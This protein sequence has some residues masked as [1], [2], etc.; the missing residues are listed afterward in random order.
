MRRLNSLGREGLILKELEHLPSDIESLYETILA[1]C[2]KNRNPDERELLKG[3]FAWLAYAKSKLRVGEANILIGLMKTEMS[4]SIEEELDGR[5]SRLLRVSGNDDK[6]VGDDDSSENELDQ[7]IEEDSE[8]A[9]QSASDADNLLGFQ[10]RSLRAYFRRP[11]D[12][13]EGLRSTATQAH[14]TIFSM[15]SAILSK[16]NKGESSAAQSNL[17]DYA[18]KWVFTHLLEIGVDQVNDRQ[19]AV[20]L[21]SL[22]NILSN[23]NDALK[24]IEA[25][26]EGNTTIFE[27][28]TDLEAVLEA[29]T[30]WSK[31]AIRMSSN[32]LSYEAINFYRPL[33]QEPYRVFIPIARAHI[34][35]WFAARWQ[36]DSYAAFGCAHS[37]LQ[38]GQKLPELR[39]NQVLLEY[40]Q[41]YEKSG[42]I[43]QQSFEI[44]SNVFWDVAKT[45][46]AYEGIGMAMK[47]VDL[48]EAAINQ[49][50][51]GLGDGSIDDV[52]RFGLLSSKGSA[53]LALSSSAEPGE[54]RDQLLSK[55]LETYDLS[56]TAYEKFAGSDKESTTVKSA[57]AYNYATRAQ[58][59]ALTG[60]I[61]LALCD[62]KS[63]LDLNPPSL[64]V[65]IMLELVSA[66]VAAHKP[67]RVMSILQA[68][69]PASLADYLL[70]GETAAAQEAA[71]RSGEGQA[72]LGLYESTVK[73]LK[74][75]Q[76]PILG[77]Y[78]AELN[79]QAAIFSRDA[80]GEDGTAKN[81]LKQLINDPKSD[82]YT[83]LRS[84]G[85]LCELQSEEF[86]RSNNPI[87]KKTALEETKKLLTKL[88]EVLGSGFKSAE[89]HV[90]LV[91]AGM[92]RKLGSA[93]EWQ[94]LMQAIFQS[95]VKDL[96]DDV[97]WND[98]WS[99]RRLARVLMWIEGME[100][101][102]Q[103]ALTAQL[104]VIDDEVRKSDL[105]KEASVEQAP[106]KVEEKS[107]GQH[108][109]SLREPSEAAT[110]ADD[111]SDAV[112]IDSVLETHLAP[113]TGTPDVFKTSA[114][115][116]EP[117]QAARPGR[118]DN[119]I[120]NPQTAT[121]T[122]PAAEP[123]PGTNAASPVALGGGA[124]DDDSSNPI[125]E[126]LG[127]S[128]G[129]SCNYCGKN[130][131]DW[132]HGG[133][134][135]CLYCVDCD[136]C[137]EC[138]DKRAARHRGELEADWRVVCPQ[139]HKYIRAPVEGWR[140]VKDGRLRIGGDEIPFKEW[141][142]GVED[143]WKA[144]WDRYWMD[145]DAQ[146]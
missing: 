111:G 122:T 40:F 17:T 23:N 119:A 136:I 57:A 37:S 145:E 36:S 44:I 64:T 46:A 131:V 8:S 12:D 49:L 117:G 20:V 3:L 143:Q 74:T 90:S 61:D 134:Y 89:S 98:S 72:L 82:V 99:F 132:A 91:L 124:G 56:L 127:G 146:L 39:Q 50:D 19:A 10:E 123:K 78:I 59:L 81:Y 138:F 105:A 26:A 140:G 71:K 7:V 14:V 58:A 43:S 28:Q 30:S 51:L 45:S 113:T 114:V 103:I 88:S 77:D 95:C 42:V 24:P 4:M 63:S 84:C 97:G 41:G 27:L 75:L 93:L 48:Y 33:L 55:T 52:V 120:N 68:V 115:E 85:L 101:Q 76:G 47:Y 112:T 11:S 18:A 69:P 9:I 92:L 35:N 5:L 15:V 21:E 54:K 34:N 62:V 129:F 13:P 130:V 87:V 135:M 73:Y 107:S 141:L 86:R 106:S 118:D 133:A 53:F 104:Y 25:L 83:I 2:A 142:R 100:T 109:D 110:Q 79:L 102:A 80:L 144:Y 128:E 6:Q 38:K 1:E 70:L 137:E 31:R 126:G 60:Q 116:H 121:T 29:L 108:P 94:D 16:L 125:N 32:S 22:F 65:D 96:S 67:E 139:S 66:C